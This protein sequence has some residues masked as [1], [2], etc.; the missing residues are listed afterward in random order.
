MAWF[1]N[2]KLPTVLALVVLLTA[3]VVDWY[4]VWG[5]FFL[6]WAIAG[7]VTGQAF[8]VQ[9][10]YRNESPV[11]FWFVSISWLVL[12]A[13]SILFDLVIPAFF[14]SPGGG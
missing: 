2:S 7:I 10:V 12:S 14:R 4:W 13:A 3:A 8:V 6:Y 9:I 1:L 5:L 11:L